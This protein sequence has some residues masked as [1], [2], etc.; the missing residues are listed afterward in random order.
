MQVINTPII[1]GKIIQSMRGTLGAA[2]EVLTSASAKANELGGGFS[3][4][5]FLIICRHLRANY[6][7]G[8]S[9]SAV[10]PLTIRQLKFSSTIMQHN[11]D[12]VL[13]KTSGGM[14]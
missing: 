12:L 4:I 1:K 6:L 7:E 10:P 5:L 13:V 8:F 2:A 11:H 9:A 14:G 3:F